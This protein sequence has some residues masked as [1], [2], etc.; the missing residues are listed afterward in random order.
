MFFL[1]ARLAFELPVDD[2][3]RARHIIVGLLFFLFSVPRHG[4][5]TH[6]QEDRSGGLRPL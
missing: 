1:L 6:R 3:A 2:G 5:G 4:L